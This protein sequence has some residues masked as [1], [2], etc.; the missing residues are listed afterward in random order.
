MLQSVKISELPSADTLTEDDLIVVDQP[1]DTKKATLFQ[2]LNH[3]EDVVEQSTLGVLAKN[4]GFKNIGQVSSVPSLLS[5]TGMLDGDRILM[6]SYND[7]WAV[8]A[9][10]LPAGGGEFFY[11]SSKSNINNQVTIF[12]GWCRVI[13]NRTLSHEDAGLVDGSGVDEYERLQS[14]FRVVPRKGTLII[15]GEHCTSRP[16]KLES[17][18]GLT[19]DGT[20]GKISSFPF[21]ST[22]Q[23]LDYAETNTAVM[24]TGLISMFN[25]PYIEFFGLEIEGCV[26]MTSTLNADG[27]GVGEEHALFIRSCDG[28]AIHNVKLHNVFGYGCLGW[29]TSD[30]SFYGNT[31]WDIVR[32]SG[33]NLTSGGGYAKIYGNR[34]YNIGLY[35]VELEGHDYLGDGQNF[36]RAWDNTIEDVRMGIP[37]VDKCKNAHVHDNTIR[38]AH[39]GITSYRTHNYTDV[40]SVRFNDNTIYGCIRP[41]F[42]NTARN[43]EFIDNTAD[44]AGIPDYLYTSSFNNIF[45]VDNSDRRI[46]WAPYQAEF[47][48]LVGGSISIMGTA[49][50][51]SSVVW[52][53]TKA[54]IYPKDLATDP[55][56]LWKVTLDSALPFT[57]DDTVALAKTQNWGGTIAY[58]S[59]GYQYKVVAKGNILRGYD[60][61][62]YLGSTNSP[63]TTTTNE[64]LQNNVIEDCPVWLLSNSNFGFRRIDGNIY[65]KNS[66]ITA[67]M[68]NSDFWGDTVMRNSLSVVSPPRTSSA[69]LPTLHFY[70]QRAIKAVGVELTLQGWSSTGTLQVNLNGS[71]VVGSGTY[72]S[73]SEVVIRLFTKMDVLQGENTVQINSSLNTLTYA[74]ATVKFLIP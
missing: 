17:K 64:I 27:T 72:T 49:Y 73:G 21:R 23:V 71:V 28:S 1:D 37:V 9:D 57:I 69:S 31:V 41:I 52:D 46:F 15:R 61:A 66:D 70:A 62:I 3:L 50:T 7:G 16:L 11:D 2:V 55:D 34:F 32:E 14:L 24:M 48:N 54:G 43:S 12:N 8:T 65:G 39:T 30:V 33:V 45:E 20:G 53:A 19:F 25:C 47:F 38:R 59:N 58:Q 44:K 10:G 13:K 26:K 63:S 29:F 51:I 18:R 6:T 40:E 67:A 36:V 35:G 68:W 5:L 74:G 4:E 22:Y 42:S 56:G 60:T